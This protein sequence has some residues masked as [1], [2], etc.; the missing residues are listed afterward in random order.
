MTESDMLKNFFD[1]SG[2]YH[3]IRKNTLK[4]YPTL[5]E[6]MEFIEDIEGDLGEAKSL[7]YFIT[8]EHHDKLFLDFEVGED[9]EIVVNDDIITIYFWE[10]TGYSNEGGTHDGGYEYWFKINLDY[11][12]FIGLEVVNQN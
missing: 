9:N 6:Y 10:D 2:L 3:E 4:D 1:F 8:N 11:E 5:D 12:A 7:Y